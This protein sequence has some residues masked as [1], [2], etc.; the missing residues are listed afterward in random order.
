MGN[1]KKQ[2]TQAQIGW[3]EYD[4]KE[5]WDGTVCFL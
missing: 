5:L 2:S 3:L 4:F 1:F